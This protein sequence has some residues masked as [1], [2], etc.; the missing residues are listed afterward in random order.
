MDI[1]NPRYKNQ[2]IH[3]VCSLFTVRDGEVKVLL[4][5]RSNK[6]Y[7]DKWMLPSGAVYNDEDCET[8]MKREMI[9]KTGISGI[10]VEQFHT[11]SDPKRSP[12]MRMIAV[13]YI[14]IVNSENIKIKKKTEKTS[15]EEVK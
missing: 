3:V 10:Y 4:V 11:F 9:E 14:G 2:G 15:V 8:A 5:Q 6:P 7:T 12:L 13:G 1:S